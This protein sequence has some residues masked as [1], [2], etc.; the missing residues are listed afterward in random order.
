MKKLGDDGEEV[1]AVGGMVAAE[2]RCN[3]NVVDDDWNNV[4]VDMA[5][6]GDLRNHDVEKRNAVDMLNAGDI[7]V[8]VV[9]IDLAPCRKNG[10]WFVSLSAISSF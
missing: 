1:D 3:H 5:N 8:G 9:V 7:K 2:D 4:V 10:A 6:A